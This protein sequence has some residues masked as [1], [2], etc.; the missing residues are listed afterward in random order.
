MQIRALRK[1]LIIVVLLAAQF[2]PAV[3]T[4]SDDVLQ[5]DIP[6]ISKDTV[7]AL[8]MVSQIKAHTP[9]DS[10]LDV[11]RL[12]DVSTNKTDTDNDGLPDSVETIL[13]TDFNNTD[14]DFDRLDDYNESVVYL[15]DPLEP[16]SNYDGFPDYFEVT[17]APSDDVD[18]DG[19]SNI[20]DFDNDGDGIEDNI[21]SSPFAYSI[22]YDTFNFNLKTNGNPIYI[23]FQLLPQNP[24]NVRLALQEWDWPYD[25]KSTMQDLD[26]SSDD[27]QI[28]P[29]LELTMSSVPEQ[30]EVDDYGIGI[31]L[32]RAYV[33]LFQ[34]RGLGGEAA[35]GG[36]M[37]YPASD[38]LDVQINA[39]LVWLVKAKTDYLDNT[40]IKSEDTTL[41]TYQENFTLTGFS[42]EESYGS[43]IGLFYSDDINQTMAANF[44]MAYSFL[45][46]NQSTVQD[47]PLELENHNVSLL[48][49]V[50]SFSHRDQTLLNVTTKMTPGALDA[51]PADKI[52]PIIAAS[53]NSFTKTELSE[54]NSISHVVGNDLSIDMRNEPVITL[55][56]MKTNWF[57]T[58]EKTPVNLESV[59]TETMNWGQVMNVDD[60]TLSSI[61]AL[62]IVWNVGESTVTKVGDRFTIFNHE[63]VI[64]VGDE[65][66]KWVGTGFSSVSIPLDAISI[67]SGIFESSL[68]VLDAVLKAAITA[69][70]TLKTAIP[71]VEKTAKV[72]VNITKVASGMS[73]VLNVLGAITLSTGFVLEIGFA[74]W[75]LFKIS[76]SEGWSSI[77]IFQGAVYAAIMTA[78]AATLFA[79]GVILL[80]C[81]AIPVYGWAIALAGGIILGLIGLT[82]FI[83]G[84]FGIGFSDF[85]T[86]I[87][88]T[89]HQTYPHTEYSLA[90][91]NTSLDMDD[92]KSNGFDAG[93]RIIFKSYINSTITNTSYAHSSWQ[94][95]T[96]SYIVPH[97]K[98]RRWMPVD[99]PY[100]YWNS[101]YG[102]YTNNVSYSESRP[103]SK[104]T[105]YEVGVWIEPAE[106]AANFPLPIVFEADYKIIYTDRRIQWE[107]WKGY[108]ET[109]MTET[110]TVT[111]EVDTLYFDILPGN[112]NDFTSWYQISPLD[113]DADGLTNNIDPY[114]WSWDADGDGL[115]D[116]FEI[117]T[118][119][120]DPSSSDKDGDG[121]NDR[122][123]IIYGTNL[124]NPDTDRDNLSDYK[125]INGWDIS[126]NY[127]NQTFNMTVHSNPL[128][129]DS[130]DDGV[131]DQMEYWSYLNP[132][133]KDTDGNGIPD[134]PN[135]QHLTYVNFETKW[136]TEG[137][138][139]GQFT[140]PEVVAVDD[141]GYV[142]VADSGNQ[143]IQKFDSS[144]NF[145]TKWGTDGEG[146][147]EFES[148]TDLAVDSNGNIYTLEMNRIQKF[149]S[150]GNFI[151]SWNTTSRRT[152]AIDAN[153]YIYGT[154]INDY[155]YDHYPLPSNIVIQKFNSSGIFVENITF[156]NGNEVF[157]G[158]YKMT[159]SDDG[160]F[161]LTN[162]IDFPNQ[163]I[164][165][166]DPNGTFI[167]R[168]GSEGYLNKSFSA[169][170][171]LAVDAKGYVYI[172]DT[173]NNH[174]QKFSSDGFF[175]TRWG[176]DGE[177][178]SEFNDPH[179]IA[180]DADEYV[181]VADSGNNRI[182]KFAQVT[183]IPPRNVS[184]TTDTD[185]DG[186]TDNNESIG[187]DVTF[188]NVTGVFAIHVNSEPLT[189]DTDFDRLT[190]LEEY[191]HSSNPR[192]IDSDDD[193]LSDFI[194]SII[195][196][197]ITNYDTDGDGLDD[198]TEIIFGSKPKKV[199]SDNDG[200]SDYEEFYFNSDPKKK[201][202]DG[203]GLS[204]KEEKDF[205]SN[206][207]NPDSDGDLMF[208]KAEKNRTADPWNPDSDGDGLPDGY[209]LLYNTSALNNDTDKDGV[210]DGKEVDNHMNPLNN[211]TDGDGLNDLF[212]LNNGTN[213]LNADTDGN[214]LNDSEDPY[215]FAANVERIW[216]SYDSDDDTLRLVE[217]LG[218]YTNITIFKPE[219]IG[220]YSDE[221]N[222]LFVGRPGMDNTT[223][224]N[225]IQ[226]I[227]GSV[228]PNALSR[229]QESDHDRFYVE[230]NVWQEN[231]T[232]VMLS[233]P[234][235]LDHYRVLE[236]FKTLSENTEYPNVVSEFKADAI[237][238]LG[239]FVMVELKEPVKPSIELQVYNEEN[240]PHDAKYSFSGNGL[241]VKYLDIN[242]SENVM[243]ASSNNIERALIVIYYTARDLDRTGDLDAND[244]GDINEKTLVM[245][246]FND[247]SGMWEK[248]TTNMDWVNDVG[249]DTTNDVINGKEYEGYL[250]ANVSHFSMYGLSGNEI[251]QQ[252]ERGGDD[253]HPLDSDLD[254]LYDFMERRIGTDPYDPDTDDDGIID[255]ED[256]DPLLPEGIIDSED[257]DPLVLYSSPSEV[258]SGMPNESG[259]AMEKYPEPKKF[260]STLFWIS[261][262]ALIALL[263]Y[264]LVFRRKE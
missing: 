78:Y 237:D 45:R 202:T 11:P 46:D 59:L 38:P 92:H 220:N 172:A 61:M 136:G 3:A 255:S 258:E 217:D 206:P 256:D 119:G 97:Y 193:G 83:L 155:F 161:Y 173:G 168:W 194:E 231:Q 35:L 204:D 165:K 203:D 124:T 103:D 28:I 100:T 71:L 72:I 53:E 254:G 117:N 73:K 190:D 104:N 235:P 9:S 121:L 245:N 114:P 77:G 111:S 199:D 26:N 250:W 249:I 20:W 143:R 260:S 187:W 253:D 177:N 208:D 128:V 33:P 243:N 145:I 162:G 219:D 209:E 44:L 163:G 241:G 137:V 102:D 134:E 85:V 29:M 123:E 127:S 52:L 156:V 153:D 184:S 131:D 178:N 146:D 15:S 223:A 13:G 82:D 51:L 23:D 126:F 221:Q 251:T 148:I 240:L 120:S 49:N 96:E 133:S 210:F 138:E 233:H 64:K 181:Y 238:E 56:L 30:S 160:S 225:Q 252:A 41:V 191:N 14:S 67:A 25:N 110:G 215:T 57:N 198:N 106:G 70:K 47:M 257:D 239:S 166:F 129:Q 60:D 105:T 236:L 216:V 179:G 141:D 98:V 246:W 1:V 144:G 76:M 264:L 99:T 170:E 213:P 39:S 132:M 32:D 244:P 262:I 48:S 186:L 234:Y 218:K 149:N 224:G 157:E 214:G 222:I 55:K 183:D 79:I 62:A 12:I 94:N 81:G 228:A 7:A 112:V 86:W 232:V 68:E 147:G 43:D 195:G 36:K 31:S 40:T 115:S 107:I 196:T 207:R 151:T 89:F 42:V 185:G 2:Y 22:M 75:G 84:F 19:F 261:G 201:D 118:I 205:K 263:A 176:Q 69:G 8:S 229:M 5:D 158:P 248:L 91:L 140:Y 4:S 139:D 54:L 122:M 192:D 230:Y 16:D 247:S 227:I 65:I 24:D 169:P 6:S 135:P 63:E 142:Y 37:F 174:I 101:N 154:P 188:T 66:T 18:S 21:D 90:V 113:R 125:E 88:G 212:E 87:V 182:Q 10:G 242:V 108:K 17:D 259:D 175:V 109:I 116:K 27:L 200:L 197:N 164:F 211:D 74:I 95:V 171:G 130:D 80:V 93:D 50:D 34:V 152:F 180:I 189:E 167:K 226:N 150:D 159:I 58:T